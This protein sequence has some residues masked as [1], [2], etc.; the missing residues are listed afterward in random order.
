LK[1][2]FKLTLKLYLHSVENALASQHFLAQYVQYVERL[3]PVLPSLDILLG[4]AMF[5]FPILGQAFE[6]QIGSFPS[7]FENEED[8]LQ[9][10]A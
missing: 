8:V 6:K 10:T 4:R 5:L 1:I 9:I 7:F 3:Q 2:V